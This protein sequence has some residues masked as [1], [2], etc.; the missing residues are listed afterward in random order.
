MC[1]LFSQAWAL[2]VMCLPAKQK[3]QV[4]SR[5]YV[6]RLEG[7]IRTGK[8][9]FEVIEDEAEVFDPNTQYPLEEEICK[10]WQVEP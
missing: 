9:Q 1:F 3:T 7:D 2:G 10:F 5:S 6:S 8:V 4:A